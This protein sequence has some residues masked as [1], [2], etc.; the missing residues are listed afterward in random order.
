MNNLTKRKTDIRICER[1]SSGKLLNIY[2]HRKLGKPPTKYWYVGV[3]VSET[4][5]QANLWFNKQSKQL[6]I[7]GD[8]TLEALMRAKEIILEV[9]H[10]LGYDEELIVE[11]QDERRRSAYRWLKRYGFQDYYDDDGNLI[12]YGIA[13]PDLYEFIPTQAE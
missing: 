3:C 7:T 1:L 5:K 9:V 13:N 2:F 12:G 11:W 10:M 6:D 4:R 8:G